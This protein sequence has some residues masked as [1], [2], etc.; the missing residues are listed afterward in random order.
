MDKATL[1]QY[2]Q[3]YKSYLFSNVM[4]FWLNHAVDTKNG[5]V[6]TCVDRR[7]NLTSTD[8]S[9]WFQ[10]RFAWVNAYLCGVYG[11]DEAMYQAAKSCI[12]FMN[13]HCIDPADGRMFFTVT[14][15]GAPLRKRRYFFSETFYIIANAEF[16]AA[17]G[18]E[19]A[20]ANARKYFDFV[21]GIYC[22]RSSDPY[23]I[24]PKSFGDTRQTLAFAE[25]MIL[26]NVSAVMRRCDPE[27]AEKY[28]KI[29]KSLQKEITNKFYHP[30]IKAVLESVGADGSFEDHYSGGRVV[31]PGHSIEASW[32]L[33]DDACHFNDASLMQIAENIFNWS[34][35]WGWDTEN[36]GLE[37]F[38]DVY[39]H[40][41]ETLEQDM[42]LWWPQCEV[43]IASIRLYEETGK[44][45]Y[46][47]WFKKVDKY[48]FE[49]FADPE[50]PEWYGYLHKD[51]SPLWPP[52]KGNSFKGPFHLPRML[53]MV[54][55]SL[56]RLEQR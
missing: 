40:P 2:R 25:P 1:Q 39:G 52:C 46:A 4:P 17:F 53:A 9:V 35:D 41:P 55:Q 28:K 24:T 29:S 26:L 14:A 36:G 38:K 56:A 8:K 19:T 6:Y 42:K 13:D 15:E 45:E 54:E 48:V 5:G 30:E 12:D 33:L 22:D 44:E 50:F 31:N 11:Y 34:M 21:Y 32:F 27:N 43:L 16:A 20:L 10:G 23:K 51:N 7:G 47:E 49:K 37:Y 3:K 18:D